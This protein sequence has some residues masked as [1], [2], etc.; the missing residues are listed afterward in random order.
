MESARFDFGQIFDKVPNPYVILD[1]QFVIVEM[2]DAYLQVTMRRRDDII[3]R[4]MFDAF[5]SEAGSESEQML[6]LSLQQ[7][8][9][10]GAVDVL[11]LIP[12]PIA[13]PDGTLTDLQPLG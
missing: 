9:Q 2:N 10:T 11:P 3:G 1:D 6:R 12:Y 13:L 4:N 8:I 5:P 7:V